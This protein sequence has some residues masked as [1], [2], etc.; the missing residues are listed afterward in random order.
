MPKKPHRKRKGR[1]RR[2]EYTST[3]TGA[4]AKYRSGWEAKYMAYLDAD[5][6]VT[7]WRYEPFFIEY[8]SNKRTGKVR[9][10]YPDFLVCYSDGTSRLVEIKQKRKLDQPAVVKKAEAARVWCAA[11]GSTYVL[12]TEIELKELDIL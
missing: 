3:K 4:I 7:S 6:R 9:K 11:R 1:Y 10:Y 8:V 12:L 5:P 2:G